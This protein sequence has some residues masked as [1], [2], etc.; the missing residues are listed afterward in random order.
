MKAVTIDSGERVTLRDIDKPRIESPTD[1]LVR[2][3]EVG[4]CGTDSSICDG[5]HGAAPDGSG[6]LVPGHEGFGEVVEVGAQV[7]DL[8]AGDLV[9]PTVRRPCPHESCRACRSGH[10]DFCVTGD[11]LERGIE[12]IHGFAAEFIVEDAQYLCHVPEK[13]RDVAVL[14]EPLTIAEKG[15]R[16]YFAIQR[17][18]PWLRDAS[19]R[20]ILAGSKAVILGG[21]PIGL[22]GAMLL[23]LYDVETV[24]YSRTEPPAPE[25]DISAAIGASYV[26]SEQ[27]DFADVAGRLGG[28]DIVYEATGAAGL[29]FEVLPMMSPNAVFIATGVP[30]PGGKTKIKA[31]TVMHELVM[32]NQ[33]LCGTVNASRADFE[34]AIEHLGQMLEQWPDATRGII[35]HRQGADAF[36][37]SAASRD[38]L[39]HIV[40]PGGGGGNGG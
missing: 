20:E 31:D 4:V 14:T 22:L 17:R 40:I 26:S 10:S 34:N 35:T 5:E 23:R 6:Y 11:Y 8:E 19:E 7:R 13:V 3:L 28:V 39:K 33:V 1:V 21:G 9:V 30:G 15:L 38:G 37:E 27:E 2:I 24:V 18:L 12:R 25:S 29:M 16:Q 32:G 36:C